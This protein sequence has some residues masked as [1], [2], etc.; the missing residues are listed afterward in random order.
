L[1]GIF[2]SLI[3][4]YIEKPERRP[5]AK[6]APLPSMAVPSHHGHR[7][8]LDSSF[9]LEA[10]LLTPSYPVGTR[11]KELR[12]RPGFGIRRRGFHLFYKR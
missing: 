12:K 3:R 10:V 5:A 1:A 9:F 6:M 2:T 8:Q 11:E 4:D 7:R